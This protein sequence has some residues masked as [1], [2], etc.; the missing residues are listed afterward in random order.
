MRSRLWVCCAVRRASWIAR[1]MCYHCIRRVCHDLLNILRVFERS[2]C[3]RLNNTDVRE[4]DARKASCV[5]RKIFDKTYDIV[6]NALKAHYKKMHDEERSLRFEKIIKEHGLPRVAFL[7]HQMETA[8]QELSATGKLQ[9]RRRK[10]FED[11]DEVVILAV[12][13]WTCTKCRVL[14][15]CRASGSLV[16]RISSPC[17]EKRHLYTKSRENLRCKGQR[18][19]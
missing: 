12:F 11:D 15:V 4:Q 13:L 16:S 5:T 17:T 7:R 19:R 18:D 1:N 6:H 10:S 2:D 9:R 8:A 14:K 3:R